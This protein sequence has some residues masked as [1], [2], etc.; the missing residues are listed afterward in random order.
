MIAFTS[1]LPRKSSRTSTQAVI[2]PRT[3][4][5]SATAIEVQ[6]VS[7]RAA[8]A[9]GLVT[10]SQNARAPPFVDSKTRA[11]IGRATISDR[12][13]V[14]RPSERAVEALSLWILTGLETMSTVLMRIGKAN[15]R[16]KNRQ[17]TTLA[18]GAADLPLDPRQD[19]VSR[20]EEPPLDAIPAAE[21]ELVDREL[22]RPRRELLHESA[23]DGL[24]H[25]PVAVLRERAL[26]CGRPQ[27]AEE[28]VRLLLVLALFRTATGFSIRI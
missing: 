8:T 20:V 14:T 17:S 1:D 7:F 15:R 23:G 24:V 18:G 10:T 11:A 16:H 28:R 25:G 12:Y 13:V 4:L 27:E 21:P 19:P 3:A 6:S 9:S 5:S 26:G 2:V 22:A